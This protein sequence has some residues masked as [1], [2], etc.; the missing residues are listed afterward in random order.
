MSLRHRHE[1]AVDLPRGLPAGFHKPTQKFRT[2]LGGCA[3]H[4]APIRQVRAGGPLRDVMTLVPR[5]L[6]SISLAGPAPSGSTGHVPALSGLLLPSP[7]SPDQAALSSTDLLR[8]TGGEGLSPPL[9]SQRLTAQTESG[10][11]PVFNR[12][13]QNPPFQ[14]TTPGS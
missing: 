12:R 7:A 11:E 10:P 9:E 8:Q 1:Y 2:D 13:Q 14:C 4:P 3:P 6:L 5:V